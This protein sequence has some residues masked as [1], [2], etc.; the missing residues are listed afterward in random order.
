MLSLSPA[1]SGKTPV[2][3]AAMRASSSIF[4]RCSLARSIIEEVGTGGG[5]SAIGG[6]L[7]GELISCRRMEY[8]S[9]S[10]FFFSPSFVEAVPEPEEVD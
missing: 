2:A 8:F 10:S 7:D 1:E 3:S 5:G 6:E 9:S 4:R